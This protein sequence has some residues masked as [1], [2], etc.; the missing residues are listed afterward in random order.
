MEI[1]KHGRVF[2]YTI[3]QTVIK[4]SFRM[5]YSAVNDILAATRKREQGLRNCS[6]IELMAKLHETL[7]SMR[8][9]RSAL[10]FDTSEAKILVDN[11]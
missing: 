11:R 4:T 1:D 7:E 5:T 8:E 6:S 2:N 9:K 10:G 3:T